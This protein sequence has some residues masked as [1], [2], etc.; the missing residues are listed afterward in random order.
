MNKKAHLKG[1]LNIIYMKST[2]ITNA[3]PSC[4]N[5]ISFSKYAHDKINRSEN[6]KIK[7]FNRQKK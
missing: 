1:I 6:F 2:I 7:I 3:Y 5:S 4:P